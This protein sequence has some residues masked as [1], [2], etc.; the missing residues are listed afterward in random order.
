[1]KKKP[2]VWLARDG[3]RKWCGDY[4]LCADERPVKLSDDGWGA[5]K[6]S[7]PKSLK[8]SPPSPATCRPVVGLLK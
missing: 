4:V 3:A 1:M 6:I 2:K 8:A 5:A 7:A